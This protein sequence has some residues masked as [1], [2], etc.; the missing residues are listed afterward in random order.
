MNDTRQTTVSENWVAYFSEALE[1]RDIAA[2]TNCFTEDCYWRDFLTFTWN[3]K[4]IEGKSA[5]ANMLAATLDVISPGAW[6]ITEETSLDDGTTEAWINFET[7]VARGRGHL[8]LINGK[9][10]TLLTTMVELKGHEEPKGRSRRKGVIH[11]ADKNRETWQD[12]RRAEEEALGYDQQPY[13]LIIGGG[14][15]GIALAA[16]LKRLGVSALIVERNKN[17]GDSWR[18]RYRSL[19]LHDPVWYDHMP[20]LPFPDDWPVFTPKDKFGDWLEMYTKVMEL[21]YWTEAECHG[22]EFDEAA[23]EWLVRVNRAGE[24]LVLRPQ[25][26]V[27][28]TGAYGYPKIIDFEEADEF[29]GTT[30]HTSQYEGGEVFR[31]KKCLVIGSGSSAHDICVDLWEHDADVTMIQRSPT[32]VVRSE[33]LMN[34]G[35]E[36]TYSESALERGL[37]T[38]KADLLSAS[39]P[40]ALIPLAHVPL[41]E[42]IAKVDADF[43]A[44]LESAGFLVSFGEDK[45]GLMAQALRTASGY[46]IDVGAS[47]LIID[48]EIKMKSGVE[49]KAFTKGGI[50]FEDGEEL[51][52]DVIIHA[53]GYGSMDEMVAHLISDEVAEKVG[54][55]W[56]YGSG[57]KGDP[58]P[59]EGELRNMWKPTTQPSLWFHG[60]N[61][62]LSR[63]FSKY[64]A[65]QL[66]ARMEGIRTSV[67]RG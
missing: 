54:K 16:R 9:C 39:L 52:A 28:A 49:I 4:T 48:G 51:D 57:I 25:Q 55:F 56:G 24:D 31:G 36:D 3:I 5:I 10:R 32:I 43:Y 1:R 34:L 33:T 37:N 2:A 64:V 50:A 30:L 17:P 6:K 23:D 20:Y 8:R 40:F 60:G 38:D 21:N 61:L 26:L 14:Q 58:G 47:S 42:E 59:W 12:A 65:L 29:E 15:G 35:F 44:R 53:T 62:A 18:N 22:A 63:H 67:Y 41:Y 45:S 11:G 7:E 27:F 46:Y 13:C 66:K 19:V